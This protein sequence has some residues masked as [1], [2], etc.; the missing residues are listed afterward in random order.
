M[1][2]TKR[3][4]CIDPVNDPVNVHWTSQ[5]DHW[6]SQ[7]ITPEIKIMNLNVGSSGGSGNIFRFET[8]DSSMNVRK[9]SWNFGEKYSYYEDFEEVC[10]KLMPDIIMSLNFVNE[11][12]E[13][14]IY[15][16]VEDEY[17]A[18]GFIYYFRNFQATN[19]KEIRLRTRGYACLLFNY[20][21][22]SQ[23]NPKFIQKLWLDCEDILIN[24]MNIP[25]DHAH[26]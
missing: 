3:Q 25:H 22:H 9:Y 10:I 24:A 6:T 18:E 2:G 23:F 4:K 20:V 17:S 21:N 11:L 8:I 7:I 5:I 19:V 1:L 12:D 26:E 14:N 13:L 15:H 16:N